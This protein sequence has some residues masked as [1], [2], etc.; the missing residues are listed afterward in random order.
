VHRTTAAPAVLYLEQ[1]TAL[2]EIDYSNKY[3]AKTDGFPKYV[4]LA[5]CGLNAYSAEERVLVIY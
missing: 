1:L 5:F 4:G 2:Q 3:V